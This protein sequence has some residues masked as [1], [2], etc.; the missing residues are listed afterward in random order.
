MTKDNK[1]IFVRNACWEDVDVLQQLVADCDIDEFGTADYAINIKEVFQSIP[2]D[3]NI[4]TA[5]GTDNRIMG[6][7]F[8]EEMGKGRLDTY[9]FTHP[10]HKGKG[11]GSLL[12]SCTEKRAEEYIKT[13][14]DRNISYEINNII[15]AENVAAR[16]ILE[17]RGYGF[18]R[19]YSQMSIEL[20]MEPEKAVIPE[21]ISIRKYNPEKDAQALYEVYCEA[22]QDARSHRTKTFEEWMKDRLRE[23]YDYNLWYLACEN[24]EIIG[25]LIGRKEQA[26]I[27]VDL[28]GVRRK[29]RKRGVGRVMLQL[30]MM[31]SYSRGICTVALTVDSDSPTKAHELYKRVGMRAVFQIAMY[32]KK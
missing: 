23:G 11:I 4:W 17:G 5:Y 25:F 13:Y 29:S 14:K 28:L 15:A 22:F 18:K 3:K 7:A 12:V 16:S 10:E 1:G 2:I 19:L 9:V 31:E 20:T 30:I 24:E 6:C 26:C 21:G 8:M 27:W 32:E